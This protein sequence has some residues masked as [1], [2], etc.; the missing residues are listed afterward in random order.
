MGIVVDIESGERPIGLAAFELRAE[1]LTW[2]PDARRLAISLR[3]TQGAWHVYLVDVDGAGMTDLTGAVLGSSSAWEPAWSPDGSRVAF[4]SA[5][6]GTRGV[7]TVGVDGAGLASLTSSI[8]DPQVSYMTPV[9]S[10]EGARVAFTASVFG[11]NEVYIS[12][13]KGSLMTK[14]VGDGFLSEQPSWSP[15]G[16]RVVFV[17]EHEEN[18]DIYAIGVDGS[19]FEQLTRDANWKQSPV[20]S[21]A[22]GHAG[23]PSGACA[24][25]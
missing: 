23:T 8:E 17:S 14:L 18:A 7:Y 15:D 2:S 11:A 1:A 10:P 9:W 16:R 13:A 6:A 20:F 12:D 3:G 19:C 25:P 4:V 5:A 21:P 24:G 22:S